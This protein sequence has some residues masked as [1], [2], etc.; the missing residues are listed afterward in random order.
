[1]TENRHDNNNNIHLKVSTPE[2][3]LTL[4][5][6]LDIDIW[7]LGIGTY[8]ILQTSKNANVYIVYMGGYTV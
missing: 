1:M 4:V 2:S 5:H 6:L 8:F 7:T 3:P